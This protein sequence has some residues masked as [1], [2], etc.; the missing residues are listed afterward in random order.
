MGNLCKLCSR[1]EKFIFCASRVATEPKEVVPQ[2]RCLHNQE[3]LSDLVVSA[4]C[5]CHL[6]NVLLEGYLHAQLRFNEKSYASIGD[7]EEYPFAWSISRQ[8]TL[9]ETN[10]AEPTTIFT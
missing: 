7:V 8:E 2:P 3:S 1:I 9:M 4:S 6:C 10:T 5:G